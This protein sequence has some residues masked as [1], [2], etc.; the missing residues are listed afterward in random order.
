MRVSRE[1]AKR[2]EP[3]QTASRCQRPRSRRKTLL[4]ESKHAW[5]S[6]WWETCRRGFKYKRCIA[7]PKRIALS[8]FLPIIRTKI[9]RLSET[10]SERESF[11]KNFFS[12][13]TEIFSARRIIN[14]ERKEFGGNSDGERG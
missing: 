6:W 9:N 1:I 3:A 14:V 10:L 5:E 2:V 11:G 7:L 12:N 8:T 4:R 13:R